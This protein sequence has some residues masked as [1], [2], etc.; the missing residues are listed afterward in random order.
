MRRF[1]FFDVD[2]T[3]LKINSMLDYIDYFFLNYYGM[4][5][6]PLKSEEYTKRRHTDYKNFSRELLNQAYYNNYTG[7]KKETLDRIGK[8]WFSE[9][10][11]ITQSFFNEKI[12][13]ILKKH[14][15][16]SVEVIF[17]SGGFKSLLAPL[18]EYLDV[19]T[20]LC[21]EPEIIH[22]TLSGNIL[23]PQTIGEGKVIAIKQFLSS[24]VNY[25]LVQSFAYGDHESDLSMLKLVGQPCVVGNDACLLDYAKKQNWPVI[26]H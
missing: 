7:I 12:L 21:I 16:E 17:V 20:L 13:Q 4:E 23:S 26:A 2:G 15:Q 24:Q 6:G 5:Y 18:A 19:K 9:K 8:K 25:D 14:Q 11:K 1:A 10:M 22:G 3:L